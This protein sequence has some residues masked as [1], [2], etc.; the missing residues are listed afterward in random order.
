M[1]F[2]FPVL[3]ENAVFIVGQNLVGGARALL[4]P[5]FHEALEVDRAVFAGEMDL[6]LA[7]ALVA[8][9]ERVLADEPAGVAAEQVG[10]ARWIAQRGRAGVV[11]RRPRPDL[12]Q[13][14]DEGLGVLRNARIERACIWPVRLL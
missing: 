7:H 6:P 8:A 11:L 1:A 9:E 12:F 14:F 13:L 2:P 10:I 3:R 5:A 4:G